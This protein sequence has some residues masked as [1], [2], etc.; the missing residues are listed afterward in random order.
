MWL[1]TA[2]SSRCGQLEMIEK[3][4][5][6]GESKKDEKK[7]KKDKEKKKDKKDHHHHTMKLDALLL[8]KDIAL[9]HIV[10]F[11]QSFVNYP[12]LS[13]RFWNLLDDDDNGAVS[14]VEYVTL[15][16]KI[17]RGSWED[18]T[19][20]AFE[21]FNTSKL[22]YIS[23]EDVISAVTEISE[24]ICNVARG[25]L[26]MKEFNSL[27]LAQIEELFKG[28]GGRLDLITFSEAIE[29]HQSI[30]SCSEILDMVFG[31][32]IRKMEM[33]M[34]R[35][36]VFGR[37]LQET[38]LGNVKDISGEF[39]FVPEVIATSIHLLRKHNALGTPELFRI[40]MAA[41]VINK[42]KEEL[43][44]GV[45][46]KTIFQRKKTLDSDDFMLLSN[47][48]KNYCYDL[49]EPAFTIDTTRKII[50]VQERA[51]SEE[52][53]IEIFVKLFSNLPA[54]S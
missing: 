19:K 15:M 14:F 7:S 29:S 23:K 45:T 30:L 49:K 24:F 51:V 8:Q 44:A 6:E 13:N 37:H 35:D 4:V 50:A 21:F 22:E 43:N 17:V 41:S 26:T 12:S 36:R 46:L 34:K 39:P 33:D 1:L 48:I 40:S 25:L 3:V 28:T 54:V 9:K 5:T 10:I 52:T 20:V 16:Y 2:F 53:K 18:R 42:V 27:K 31:R 38:A 47:L 11:N 32:V